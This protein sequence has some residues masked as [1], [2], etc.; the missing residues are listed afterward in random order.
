MI[1]SHLAAFASLS[2][3]FTIMARRRPDPTPLWQNLKDYANEMCLNRLLLVLTIVT[4]VIEVFGT[5]YATVLPEIADL[6]LGLGAQG[7]GWM[8]ASQA[9]GGLVIGILLFISPQRRSSSVLF[10][11]SIVGIGLSIVALGY[12]PN[13]VAVLLALAGASGMITAWDIYT[14]SMMQ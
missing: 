12:A 11:A 4:A 5:S 2:G 13:L 8:H 7:L 10:A 9:A 6:R 14:Q 3:S 1:A